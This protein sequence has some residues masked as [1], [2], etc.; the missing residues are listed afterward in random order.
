VCG[1]SGDARGMLSDRKV[2]KTGTRLFDKRVTKG[3]GCNEQG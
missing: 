1:N 3:R 2:H